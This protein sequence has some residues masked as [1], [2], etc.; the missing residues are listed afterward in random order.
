MFRIEQRR[1]YVSW[2]TG[3][4]LENIAQRLFQ[5]EAASSAVDKR[6]GRISS[7]S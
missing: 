5:D 3:D 4:L 7:T 1:S 6:I 2:L